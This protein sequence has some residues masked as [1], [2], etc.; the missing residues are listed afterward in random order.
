MDFSKKFL[1]LIALV[2]IASVGMVAAEDVSLGGHTFTVPEGF[3]IVDND[4][5]VISMMN[6]TMLNET[7]DIDHIQLIDVMFTKDVKN[8]KEARSYYEHQGLKFIGEKKYALNGKDVLKQT[9]EMSGFTFVLY[10]TSAGNDKCAVSCFVPL[11][12]THS[13][14]LDNSVNAILKSV[15]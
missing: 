3:E 4:G 10:I 14:G 2:F 13:E 5:E 1:L 15:K 11:N 8:S 6:M 12:Q 9:Y 7:E